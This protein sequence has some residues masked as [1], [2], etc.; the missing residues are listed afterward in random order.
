MEIRVIGQDCSRCR[1][2][3]DHARRA[4]AIAGVPVTLVKVDDLRELVALHVLAIP[5]I[6][7]E[8]V[9]RSA[10]RVPSAEE[11]AAWLRAGTGAGQ[12]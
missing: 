1:R 6:T 8:G 11:I 3:Y 2:A 12:S 7:I 4:I 5:A 10:G 9:L